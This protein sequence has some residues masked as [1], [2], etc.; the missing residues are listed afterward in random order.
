[1][2]KGAL[3][4][5]SS[6]AGTATPFHDDSTVVRSNLSKIKGS[7]QIVAPDVTTLPDDDPPDLIPR[8]SSPARPNVTHTD[9]GD[10]YKEGRDDIYE[11][12]PINA[13]DIH[14]MMWTPSA[15]VQAESEETKC[16]LDDDPD[17]IRAQIDTGAHVSCTDQKHMLHDYREFTRSHPSPIKLMPATVDSDAVPKGIGYLHVPSANAKG[18]L[19]VPTFYTPSLRTTVI[20]ER[21]LVKAAKVRTKNIQSDS[22]TKHKDA[23]TFTYHAKHRRKSSRDV[24]VHGILIHDK[25]YTGALIPP[26]LPPDDERATPNASS[27]LAIERDPEFADQCRRATIL[28]IHGYHEAEH[29]QLREELSQ[30]PT[31]FHQLPFHEYIHSN[32]PVAAIKA[33]TERLLWHQRLG[34]PSDYYLY[35]A[36]RHV[37][38]VPKFLHMDRVLDVCP[39]CIRA[40]QTKNAAGQNSTRTA[41]QP[42]QGL[43]IDFSFSGTRSKNTFNRFPIGTKVKKKFGDKV[44]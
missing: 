33:A 34:H 29:A 7:K 8:P 18:F 2:I 44:Y 27:I 43:S 14:R 39:T 10:I 16:P 35:N 24:I 13:V 41:E 17:A 6:S 25:C 4:G 5:G 36:H 37:K 28:A 19:A 9:D 1:M 42:Y 26:D 31:Q 40:K 20:D 3:K 38:G 12:S 23:G 32:T 22:I 21:D 30:L 11:M 15:D